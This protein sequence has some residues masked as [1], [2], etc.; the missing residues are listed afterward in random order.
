MNWISVTIEVTFALIVLIG[1]F[2]I[3][4]QKTSDPD[5]YQAHIVWLS[6][7]LRLL[8]LS[9][10]QI[11]TRIFIRSY[12]KFFLHLSALSNT[13]PPFIIF[14]HI[15]EQQIL[16]FLCFFLSYHTLQIPIRLYSFPPSK[17]FL[18]FLDF[19]PCVGFFM[20][21]P[22]VSS[23]GQYLICTF[24][25][26][27]WY[28]IKSN[29]YIQILYYLTCTPVAMHLQQNCTIFVLIKYYIVNILLLPFNN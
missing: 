6:N 13:L 16:S 2:L 8:L 25:F 19:S 9:Y 7:L 10:G 1:L 11:L 23:I 3:N 22:H 21:Y 27:N 29:K 28:V 17:L 15:K 24:S 5:F 14:L 4:K 12:Y 20:K 26:S 18:K